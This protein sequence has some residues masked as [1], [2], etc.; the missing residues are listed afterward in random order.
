M[1]RRHRGNACR[2]FRHPDRSRRVRTALQQRL[3]RER[4]LDPRWVTPLDG[5]ERTAV[6]AHRRGGSVRRL[7]RLIE[8]IPRERDRTRREIDAMRNLKE[9]DDETCHPIRQLAHDRI[10]TL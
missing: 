9:F 7:R 3:A 2:G 10:V 4:G 1:T 6:A 5:A 8:A